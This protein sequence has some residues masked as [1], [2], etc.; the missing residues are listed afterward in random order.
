MSLT[1]QT[2]A[3]QVR[4]RLNLPTSSKLR[5]QKA[6]PNAL[7]I[8]SERIAMDENK[9]HMILTPLSVTGTPAVG[10]LDL[11]TLVT[12]NRLM[13]D[14][15]HL[16]HIYNAN[17]KTFSAAAVNITT[18]A[19]TILDNG[20]YEGLRVTLTTSAGLP[21]PL[22][23][24]TSYYIHIID[25]ALGSFQFLTTQGDTSTAVDFSTTGSGT[26]TIITPTLPM[27]QPLSELEN[28]DLVNFPIAWASVDSDKFWWLIGTNLYAFKGDGQPITTALQFNVPRDLILTD[29]ATSP[30]QTLQD[31]FLDVVT[32]LVRESEA[33]RDNPEA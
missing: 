14:K 27:T 30:I 18:N 13:I 10:I 3:S 6:I 31:E 24:A 33:N 12:S 15:L 9:R 2:V 8:F 5:I 29:F 23:L 26:Q 1:F 7:Q 20:F 16:G 21:A 32:E 4:G 11:A 28:P 19:I 22:A 17:Y 25:G